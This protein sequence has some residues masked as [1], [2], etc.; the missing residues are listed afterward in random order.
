MNKDNRDGLLNNQSS[1]LEYVYAYALV[2]L[3][4]IIYAAVAILVFSLLYITY[5]ECVTN[6]F[7]SGMGVY[8]GV[9]GLLL[10]IGIVWALI[11]RKEKGIVLTRKDAPKLF[12][13]IDNAV[14]KSK[15]NPINRVILRPDSNIAVSGFFKK[16]LMIGIASLRYITDKDF[17]SILYHEIGHFAAKDTKRGSI[18]GFYADTIQKQYLSSVNYLKYSP[19]IYIW[20][21]GLPSFFLTWILYSLFSILFGPYSKYKEYKADDFSADHTSST[22]CANALETYCTHTYCYE[23]IMSNKIV[24]QLQKKKMPN[25]I[26]LDMTDFWNEKNVNEARKKI[27]ETEERFRDTHPTLKNRLK[28]LNSNK[29][30][31][32][33]GSLMS[34]LFHNLENLEQELTKSITLQ[35][36]KKTKLLPIEKND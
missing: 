14:A 5:S 7:G 12:D 9:I 17:E 28:N 24:E 1:L 27:F 11:P 4:T 33:S 25:N 34:T 31:K 2:V 10:L 21:L 29:T 36:G 16:K 30:Q 32:N 19:H 15:I 23:T 8:T 3:F 22:Q 18:L 35:I 6:T 13:M 20:I 26:Y